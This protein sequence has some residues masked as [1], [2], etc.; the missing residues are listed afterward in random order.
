[1]MGEGLDVPGVVGE[2]F[3]SVRKEHPRTVCGHNRTVVGR[4]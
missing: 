2:Q 1:L 4:T 3:V